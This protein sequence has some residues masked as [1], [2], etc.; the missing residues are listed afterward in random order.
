MVINKMLFLSSAYT[1][2][3]DSFRYRKQKT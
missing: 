1:Y 3:C 2:L